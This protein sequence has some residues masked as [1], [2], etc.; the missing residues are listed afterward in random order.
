MSE[1]TEGVVA[2]E[3]PADKPKTLVSEI[4]EEALKPRLER[5]RE[6][7]RKALEKRFGIG[8]DKV[9]ERLA[10]AAELERAALSNEERNAKDL[11]EAQAKAARAD[12]ADARIRELSEAHFAELPDEQKQ[13]V[14]ELA[15]EDHDARLRVIAGL[16]KHK[17]LKTDAAQVVTTGASTSAATKPKTNDSGPAEG[18][19]EFHFQQWQ[20]KPPL[21]R[22]AYF[23]QHAAEIVKAEGYARSK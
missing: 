3:K 4:P 13:F 16:K 15:G 1:A 19:P 10:K 7:E 21:L 23:S 14:V 2:P 20:S 9:E 5:E 11:R 8:L 22:A 17:P 12:Q 6:A 18:T